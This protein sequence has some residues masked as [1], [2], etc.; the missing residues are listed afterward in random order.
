MRLSMKLAA[1]WLFTLLFFS[2]ISG[3]AYTPGVYFKEAREAVL[4]GM[5]FSAL[6]WRVGDTLRFKVTMKPV[7][8]KGSA[9]V[10][11]EQIAEEGI[12]IVQDVRL[13]ILGNQHVEMLIDRLNG[14]VLRMITNGHEEIVPEM[15]MK[16]VKQEGV[17]ISVPAGTFDCLHI[18]MEDAKKRRSEV[19]ANPMEIPLNGIIKSVEHKMKPFTT[20]MELT[21]FERGQ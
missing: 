11:V 1:G 6:N 5:A 20:T 15:A 4:R 8:L 14:R 12:L 17:K 2:G 18:V 21:S 13:G 10:R 19:W 7:S 16:T 3:H 9:V